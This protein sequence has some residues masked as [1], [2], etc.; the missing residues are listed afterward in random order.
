MP[1][2][3][4]GGGDP[5]AA[6]APHTTVPQPPATPT[7]PFTAAPEPPGPAPRQQIPARIGPYEVFQLLG[8]GGMGRVFLARSPGS[9]LVALKVIRPEHAEAPNF[10]GRFRREAESAR[11]VSGFFTPPVLDAD[12]DAPQPWLATAYVPAPSL[13]DAVRDFGVL[14]EAGLRAL[15]AGLAEALPAIH[16][17]GIVHRDLKPGNVLVTEDGPRVIDFGI[18]S[19]VDA[20]Q[21]TRTGA[22][23]GTPGFMAPEQIVSSREAGPPADVFSLGCVLVFAATGRGPF[24]TGGTAEI[25]YRAVHHP[26]RLDGTPPELGR[27]LNAC[28]DKDPTRRPP[29]ASIL[30][31]L[32]DTEPAALLTPGLRE[33]LARRQA[34]AAVLMSAPPVPVASLAAPDDP[35][36]ATAGGPSRRR[37]LWIAAAGTTIAAGGGAAALAGWRSEPREAPARG[38]GGAGTTGRPAVKVPAGPEPRWSVP[39]KKLSSA[40]LQLLGDVLVHWEQRRAT[41]YDTASGKERWTGSPRLPS[42]VSGGPKWLG[43]HGPTLFAS[44]WNGTHGHLLGVDAAGKQKFTHALTEPGTDGGFADFVESVLSVAGSVAVV[45][46]SGD[47]GYGVLAVDLGSGEILW[48]RKVDGSDFQAYAEGSHCFLQDNGTLHGLALRSGAQRWQVRGVIEPGAYPHLSTD[49]ETL[50]VASTKVQAFRVTDGKKRWTAVNETTTLS[51]ARIHGERAYLYD[52]AGT[53]FALDTGGGQQVWH[54]ASPVHLT[55]TGGAQDEGPTVSPSVLAIATWATGDVPGFIV[56]RTSDGKPLWA[57]QP[58][59]TA[60]GSRTGGTTGWLLAISGRTLF[61]ASETTLHAFRSD[62][63]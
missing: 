23:L 28:L 20:T 39:L 51:P 44:A 18:S 56:L 10:R 52:G 2:H 26:P 11:R 33:D 59:A 63:P 54:R 41:A 21:V 16:D 61:A 49:G 35:S 17:A 47:K 1:T 24:G 45:G 60:S 19:A 14:P 40:R 57:H 9:R 37:F 4:Y 32:G 27:L 58:S 50:L 34:H 15:A 8:E 22:V 62:T 5:T 3:P 48:S 13:H 12:A 30:A 38:G 42:G 6:Q 53:V 25:L 46:T 55:T 36:A 43:V 29:A 7:R 31:A